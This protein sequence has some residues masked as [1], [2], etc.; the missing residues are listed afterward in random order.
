MPIF[1]NDKIFEDKKQY[2]IFPKKDVDAF[3]LGAILNST[4]TRLFIE[5]TSRQ[6]TGAQAI[7]DI[8]VVVVSSTLVLNLHDKSIVTPKQR[9]QLKKA[10]E[11]LLLTTSDSV[12]REIAPSSN[13]VLFDNVKKERLELDKIILQDI[14]GL[15]E[16]EHLEIYRAVVDFVQARL[17]KSK[18]VKKRSKKKGGSVA[19]AMTGNLY[20]EVINGD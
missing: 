4:L 12:F 8:D 13:E 7:A 10:F 17:D 3:L 19:D 20:D 6:L 11:K 1:L 5:F 16:T 15:P 18:S 2:G 9:K 14:L